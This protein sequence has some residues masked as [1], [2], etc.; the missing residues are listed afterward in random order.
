MLTRFQVQLDGIDLHQL[1]E[2]V[3]IIDVTEEAPSP[4][5][6]TG[7]TTK[8]FGSLVIDIRRDMLRVL[9]TCEVHEYDVTRRAEIIGKLAAWAQGRMLT[10]NYRPGQRLRVV[11]ETM[12]SVGSA[13]RWTD[14]ITMRFVAHEVPFWEAVQPVRAV[15]SGAS[16]ACEL[17]VPG[18]AES[19]VMACSFTA[20]SA[21]DAIEITTPQSRMKLTGLGMQSGETLHIRYGDKGWQ[22]IVIENAAGALRS[23]LACRSGE[24][25]DDLLLV[26]QKAQRVAYSANGAVLATFTARG[27]Y[28]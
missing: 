23:A 27:L 24:S 22:E 18:T 3:Y 17:Y 25:D 10:V 1:D 2:N 5:I 6:R 7:G 4:I 20:Q 15:A 26:P 28:A 11:C 12:P 16:G 13:L 14:R 8:P 19:V 21:V 9:V